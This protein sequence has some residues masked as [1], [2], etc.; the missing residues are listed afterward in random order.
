MPSEKKCIVGCFRS[1]GAAVLPSTRTYNEAD[2]I[3]ILLN[4]MPRLVVNQGTA[5]HLMVSKIVGGIDGT[6]HRNHNTFYRTATPCG[7]VLHLLP[8]SMVS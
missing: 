5:I 2:W 8:P 1:P 7:I 4:D 3:S 6:D